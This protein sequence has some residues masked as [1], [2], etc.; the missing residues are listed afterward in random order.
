MYGRTEVGK[1]E[2]IGEGKL[3]KA[4]RE[5]GMTYRRMDVKRGGRRDRRE[6]SG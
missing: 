3:K 5:N 1:R 6:N 2:G 4:G